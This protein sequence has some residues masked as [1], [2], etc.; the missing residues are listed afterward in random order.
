MRVSRGLAMAAATG[1]LTVPGMRNHQAG[2]REMDAAFK[3]I[4]ATR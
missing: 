4:D 1:R 2:H 3:G